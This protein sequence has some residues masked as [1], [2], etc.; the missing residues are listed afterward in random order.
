MKGRAGLAGAAVQKAQ[1]KLLGLWGRGQADLSAVADPELP[2][3]LGE[4]LTER[5]PLLG[6]EVGAPARIEPLVE[7]QLLGPVLGEVLEEVLTRAGAQEQQ[8]RPDSGRT[9]LPR[10]PDHLPHLLWPVGD[11]GQDRRHADARL[12]AGIDEC[13]QRLQPL[14]WMRGRRLGALPDLVV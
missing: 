12:H 5:I 3:Q 7:R 2:P 13:L 1:R 6:A 14:A 11:P 9:R 8:V 10:R 4:L